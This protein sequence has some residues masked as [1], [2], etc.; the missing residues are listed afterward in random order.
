MYLSNDEMKTHLYAENIEAISGGD[1]TIMTAAIDAALQE[2]KGYLSA[3]NKDEI[4]SKTG[5][6]RNALLLMFVKDIVTYHFL[7][8]CNAGVELKLRQDRYERAISWLKAVQK[9]DLTPDLPAKDIADNGG[10]GVMK[11]GS[12][13][14]KSQHF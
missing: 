4:F 7:V 1:E 3:Y 14:Q 6:D 2:A 5:S 11:Y 12:N 10:I 9:G 8:L 13:P